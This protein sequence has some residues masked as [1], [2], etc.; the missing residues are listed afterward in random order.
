MDDLY[1]RVLSLFRKKYRA[2]RG[3]RL[4]GAGLLNL[5]AEQSGGQRELFGSPSGAEAEKERRLEEAILEINK[6]FP[7]AALRRFRS[8]MGGM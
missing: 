1:G 4:I 7:Q 3:V 6:K 2:G 8:W 5:E